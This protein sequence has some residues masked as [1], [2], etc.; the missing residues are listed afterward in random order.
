MSRSR[1]R[2]SQTLAALAFRAVAADWI[3]R[4]GIVAVVGGKG[5]RATG[6]EVVQGL[7]EKKIINLCGETE[8]DELF[9]LLKSALVILAND[10]GVMHLGAATGN[11]GITVFG[12]TDYTATGPISPKWSLLSDQPDCAPCF[13]HDCPTDHKC[14]TA[15]TPELV[16]QEIQNILSKMNIHL[17]LQE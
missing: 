2:Y 8:L 14:M 7:N 16:K 3:K 17:P 4:G 15:V 11:Y 13:R 5:E 10:S 6:E 9:W 1:L 12:P